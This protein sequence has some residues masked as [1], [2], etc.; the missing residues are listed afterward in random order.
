MDILDPN[1]ELIQHRLYRD[2]W[3]AVELEGVTF[4]VKDLRILEGRELKDIV[5]VD[6]SVISFAHQIDNGIP[7]LP[8]KE[9]KKDWEF[10]QLIKIMEDISQEEDWRNYV[11]NKFKISE[12][13]STDTDSFAYLYDMSDSDDDSTE[14][15]LLDS[16]LQWTR[17]LSMTTKRVPK[18]PKKTV[19][20]RGS[21]M[22]KRARCSM[23]NITKV[24]S[25]SG[26][27]I[28]E[29]MAQEDSPIS[30]SSRWIS[31]IDELIPFEISSESQMED[32]L[33]VCLQ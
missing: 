5:I 23:K 21:G 33:G 25:F 30:E 26:R 11:K 28:Q 4:Y 22:R 32:K 29:F 20:K 9:D 10:L 6:N 8:F 27:N 15:D 16:L 17:T 1:Q 2:S 13:M 24:K 31:S 19:R 3:I 14:E 18:E 7:I 12:I